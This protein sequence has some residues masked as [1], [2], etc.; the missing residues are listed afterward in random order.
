MR[1]LNRMPGWGDDSVRSTRY[2]RG[3]GAMAEMTPEGDEE[4]ARLQAENAR[5]ASLLDTHGIAWQ[6][7]APVAAPANA[8]PLRSPSKRS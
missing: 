7:P 3:C 2:L 4:L 6:L 1:Y 5:L 8:T